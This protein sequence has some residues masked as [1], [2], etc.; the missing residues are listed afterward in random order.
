MSREIHSNIVIVLCV[1]FYHV[2]VM[3]IWWSGLYKWKFLFEVLHEMP[4]LWRQKIDVFAHFTACSCDTTQLSRFFGCCDA[5]SS[6]FTI[7]LGL[8]IL[9]IWILFHFQNQAIFEGFCNTPK[10]LFQIEKKLH[11]SNR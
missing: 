9:K 4:G 3:L 2:L 8:K 11:I 5:I 10:K 6:H 7:F 1:T